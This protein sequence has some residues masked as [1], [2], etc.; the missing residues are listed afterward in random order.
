MV[1]GRCRPRGRYQHRG[2]AGVLETERTMDSTRSVGLRRYNDFA[3]RTFV[4]SS[5]TNRSRLTPPAMVVD[6]ISA[7]LVLFVFIFVLAESVHHFQKNP[8]DEEELAPWI[9][10]H[11]FRFIIGSAY[12]LVPA[13]IGD[14]IFDEIGFFVGWLVGFRL[15][16]NQFDDGSE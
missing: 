7:V 3:S 5:R 6:L 13:F 2:R 1:G 15:W 8:P 14:V 4:T 11:A 10:F 9:S 12:F 16:W